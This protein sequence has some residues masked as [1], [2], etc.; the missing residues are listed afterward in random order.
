MLAA[1]TPVPMPMAQ[2]D[3]P[4]KSNI[5]FAGNVGNG[6]M[7]ADI[8]VPKEH[9]MEAMTA[10]LAMQQQMMQQQQKMM[11]QQQQQGGPSSPRSTGIE[12]IPE[13][14]MIWVKCKNSD[15]KA[16]YQMS[17]RAYFKYIQENIEPMAMV[18]P[19]L[20]CEKCAKKSIY[21]AEKC[22]NQDCGI[23]FLR[24]SVPNDFADR[25]PACGNSS[26]EEQR[27]RR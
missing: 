18:A 11:M 26:I 10:A 17:K 2:M 3:I 24:G 5:V 1:F 4:T 16:A 22:V 8:A 9:L 12:S 21:R 20:V 14:D 13:T 7:V 25:C 19:P 23:V 27:K 6:R 15:C